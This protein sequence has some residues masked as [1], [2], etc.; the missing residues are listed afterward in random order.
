MQF[1][2]TCVAAV[3]L[4]MAATP[5]L[6]TPLKIEVETARITTL[7]LSIPMAV[8]LA[9]YDLAEAA[10][11]NEV[12][13]DYTSLWGGAPA[14]MTPRDLMQAWRGIVPGFDATFHE[15]S[16]VDVDIT[17]L[18]ASARADVDARHW[19]GDDLWRPIGTYHWDLVRANDGWQVTRMMFLL[20]EELG[21]RDLALQAM[22][23]AKDAAT[24]SQ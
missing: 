18:T 3:S 15:L 8:D 16:N 10:F 22:E 23:R 7:V 19:I 24:A 20:N 17:G 1:L 4:S 5:G 21:S 12:L 6:T 14:R 11:A 13:I 9:A 2:R